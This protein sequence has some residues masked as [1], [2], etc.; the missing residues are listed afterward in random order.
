[1]TDDS[2]SE[3]QRPDPIRVYLE[4]V[5]ETQLQITKEGI[6]VDISEAM[7]RS[8]MDSSDWMSITYDTDAEVLRGVGGNALEEGDIPA[9][10][11]PIHRNPDPRKFHVRLS[12]S[13]L[14]HI[15]IDIMSRDLHYVPKVAVLSSPNGVLGF[16]KHDSERIRPEKRTLEF[17]RS[18]ET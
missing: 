1:M 13:D 16:V 3:D 15:G 12:R 17:E 14:L 6:Y 5:F 9:Y 18:E 7:G 2:P 10:G 11:R 4:E 8:G